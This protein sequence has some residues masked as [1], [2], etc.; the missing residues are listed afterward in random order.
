[1]HQFTSLSLISFVLA[2]SAVAQTPPAVMPPGK[3]TAS[4]RPSALASSSPS[5]SPTIEEQVNS[6]SPAD[7]QAVITLL[8]T[9]FTNPDA[10]TDTELNRATVEGL[11][12]R[13]PRGLTLLSAKENTPAE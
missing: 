7:L 4:A 13:L 1:M 2:T 3:P 6:L 8:K 9:H 11:I 5:A 10:T 12:V